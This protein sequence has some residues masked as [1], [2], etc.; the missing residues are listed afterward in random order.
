MHTRNVAVVRQACVTW[1]GGRVVSDERRLSDTDPCSC[2]QSPADWLAIRRFVLATGLI[3]GR[4]ACQLRSTT[5]ANTGGRYRLRYR[6]STP[7]QF[8]ALSPYVD[9]WL[10]A[11]H[12]LGPLDIAAPTGAAQFVVQM[13]LEKVRERFMGR[14]AELYLGASVNARG[15]DP[16]F[17]ASC[18]RAEGDEG[19]FAVLFTDRTLLGDEIRWTDA[20]GVTWLAFDWWQW[21]RRRVPQARLVDA[22]LYLSLTNPQYMT[23][24][25]YRRLGID[26][27]LTASMA[28]QGNQL[29]GQF[30]AYACNRIAGLWEGS[31]AP[32]PNVPVNNQAPIA[33][34]ME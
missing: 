13:A 14:T 12:S 4:C 19:R 27:E 29:L 32:G 24:H 20:T 11:T 7:H 25:E 2:P 26:T 6:Y 18:L 34:T 33:N 30:V 23:S 1:C 3:R 28:Q 10:I 15:V 8:A 21:F 17:L 9:T 31:V 22:W 16:D 5:Q